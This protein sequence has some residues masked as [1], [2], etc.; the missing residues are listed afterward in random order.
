MIG[1]LIG[2]VCWLVVG[3]FWFDML[4]DVAYEVNEENETGILGK[5]FNIILWPVSIVMFMKE[6]KMGLKEDQNQNLTKETNRIN[7]TIITQLL[8]DEETYMKTMANNC[9]PKEVDYIISTVLKAAMNES[10]ENMELLDKAREF[11]NAK[12]TNNTETE[13]N[14]MGEE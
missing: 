4:L 6:L 1:Y 13:S 11:Y 7:N 8:T 2:L 5:A 10:K 14:T 9:T 12:V 3:N